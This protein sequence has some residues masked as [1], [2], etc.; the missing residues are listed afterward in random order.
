[1]MLFAHPIVMSDGTAKS[2]HPLEEG[3]PCFFIVF[4]MNS[5]WRAQVCLRGNDT[6]IFQRLL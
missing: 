6:Q 1:M 3:E 2:R 4:E 5:S